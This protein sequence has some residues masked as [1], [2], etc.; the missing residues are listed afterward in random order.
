VLKRYYLT[1]KDPKKPDSEGGV[2]IL[3]ESA[4]NHSESLALTK[5]VIRM[6]EAREMYY[7][8]EEKALLGLTLEV[9]DDC[10]ATRPTQ[11][12]KKL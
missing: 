12:P 1:S 11:S 10:D 3:I 6:F 8:A 4:D 7:N 9:L 5:F 2:F